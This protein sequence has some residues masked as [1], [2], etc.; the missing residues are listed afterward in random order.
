VPS[1]FCGGLAWQAR[2]HQGLRSKAQPL[3]HLPVPSDVPPYISSK[4]RRRRSRAHH[5]AAGVGPPR[6]D[7]YKINQKD[8]VLR[9][10]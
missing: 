10:L 6:F 3:K 9:Q 4:R 2:E 7:F 8:Q 1:P 5:A